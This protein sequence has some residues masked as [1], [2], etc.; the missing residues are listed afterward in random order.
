MMFVNGVQNDEFEKH[1][2]D[3]LCIRILFSLSE[4]KR[5]TL[6]IRFRS[7]LRSAVIEET[8]NKVRVRG[9]W[10]GGL[11]FLGKR[12]FVNIITIRAMF[13]VFL[14]NNFKTWEKVLLQSRSFVCFTK[15]QRSWMFCFWVQRCPSQLLQD[16]KD[17]IALHKKAQEY[18]GIQKYTIIQKQKKHSTMP[19]E[20]QEYTRRHKN[21]REDTENTV[22]RLKRDQSR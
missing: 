12:A 3:E 17:Y 22:Q 19:Q 6:H 15:L 16:I 8:W 14:V 2:E 10:G 5:L 20:A 21:I 1:E 18:K 11:N 7:K 4:T 9:G 13:L